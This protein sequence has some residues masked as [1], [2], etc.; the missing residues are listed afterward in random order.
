MTLY[1]NEDEK[2]RGY[3]LTFE[4]MYTEGDPFVVHAIWLPLLPE[5][6]DLLLS[7]DGPGCKI[8]VP[9]KVRMRRGAEARAERGRGLWLVVRVER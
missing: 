3:D 2:I 1:A 5:G 4:G 8:K 6:V 9:E 7:D